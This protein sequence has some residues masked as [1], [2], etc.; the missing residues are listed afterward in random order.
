[1]RMKAHNEG[2]NH[3][4]MDGEEDSIQMNVVFWIS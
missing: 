2:G 3:R 1:V 4:V